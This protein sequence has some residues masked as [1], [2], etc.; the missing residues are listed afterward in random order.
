MGELNKELYDQ[1]IQVIA[2]LYGD[3]KGRAVA[4]ENHI[5]RLRERRKPKSMMQLFEDLTETEKADIEKNWG[6]TLDELKIL[7]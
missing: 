4:I 2:D 6:T 3:Q 5:E 7:A 1:E